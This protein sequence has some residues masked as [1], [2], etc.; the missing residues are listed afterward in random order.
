MGTG[1]QQARNKTFVDD[2]DT[3]DAAFL[4][5]WMQDGLVSLTEDVR[6]EEGGR[7]ELEGAFE[8]QHYPAGHAQAGEHGA[9]V[10]AALALR[11]ILNPLGGHPAGWLNSNGNLQLQLAALKSLTVG[12]GPSTLLTLGLDEKI[13][14]QYRYLGRKSFSKRVPFATWQGSQ[15]G[16]KWTIKP[17]STWGPTVTG[18]TDRL[19]V[20]LPVPVGA[21]L[22]GVQ[23]HFHLDADGINPTTMTPR[24]WLRSAALFTLEIETVEGEYVLGP[25]GTGWLGWWDLTFENAPVASSDHEFF[26]T[27]ELSGTYTLDS[28]ILGVRFTIETDLAQP[29]EENAV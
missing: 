7:V 12:A 26:L 14:G 18:S 8:R 3:I 19:I 4:N 25:P 15:F 17:T 27:I 6:T 24:I 20:P 23:V 28:Q 5:A 13:A 1:G 22:T 9:I 16:L 10:A 29:N 2:A 21:S 11:D